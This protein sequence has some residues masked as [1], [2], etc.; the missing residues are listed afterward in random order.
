[1][2]AATSQRR[3]FPSRPADKFF[4]TLPEGWAQLP[5]GPFQKATF[6]LAGQESSESPFTVSVSVA[7][8]SLED[9]INR[10]R[11]Q[12]QV[13]PID[14]GYRISRTSPARRVTRSRSRYSSKGMA[15]LRL[16]P[17]NSLN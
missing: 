9:N 2:T 16:T 3:I 12:M 7:T 15:Y 1:M 6:G 11:G 10:W 8:G 13:A 4:Y 14:A 17:V 5:P